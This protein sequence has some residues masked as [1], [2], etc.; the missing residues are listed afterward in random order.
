MKKYISAAICFLSLQTTTFAQDS[1]LKISG[2]IETY[3]S[4]DFN[5][6]ANNTRPSFIYSHNRNNEVNVNLAFI[7]ANYQTERLRANLAMALG[8]YMSANYAAEP[9]VM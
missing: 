1:T 5:K 8:T 4:H 2:Y 6:P 3:Y 9:D 7:K